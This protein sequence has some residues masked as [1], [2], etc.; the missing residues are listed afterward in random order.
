[1]SQ[2]AVEQ[3]LGRLLTDA[4]FRRRFFE[5]PCRALVVSGLT[6]SPEE[7]EALGRLPQ[8][9]LAALSHQL[10]DRICRLCVDEDLKAEEQTRS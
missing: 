5:D 7:R 8:P 6:L 4:A 10:D 9:D 1:M 2:P 3:I